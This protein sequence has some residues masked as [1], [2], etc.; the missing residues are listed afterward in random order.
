MS[1]VQTPTQ[2]RQQA[3]P[4]T[5]EIDPETPLLD[6]MLLAA[7]GKLEKTSS[8]IGKQLEDPALSRMP[9]SLM[10]G[11]AIERLRRAITPEIAKILM[12][13]MNTKHGFKTDKGP[14][15]KKAEAMQPYQLE[16]VMDCAIAA[17]LDGVLW[18]GNQFN[19]IAGECYITR[20]GW[21]YKLQTLPG[22]SDMDVSPGVPKYDNGKCYVRFGGTY[23]FNG[24][25][26][27]LKDPAGVPGIPLPIRMDQYS[28]ED[29][30]LGKA[31]SKGL[32]HI[33]RT[34]TG[35]TQTISVSDD[36]PDEII[37]Q[38]AEGRI[39]DQ[40]EADLNELIGEHGASALLI[41]DAFRL[42][43][44][45][46]LLLSDFA[47]CVKRI[48]DGDFSG[49]SKASGRPPNEEPGLRSSGRPPHDFSA[50]DVEQAIAD[51]GVEPRV[52]LAGYDVKRAA[53]L[54]QE[55]RR[56]IMSDLARTIG[57]DGAA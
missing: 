44:G 55:Q 53:D 37:E 47:A 15:Q 3:P 30:I 39:T 40:Q 9:H 28:S 31:W 10:K 43:N 6:T 24:V 13:L 25:N 26:R 22:F 7:V 2:P 54:T 56:A 38:I 51:A 52:F 17:L 49:T 19:I 4:P 20:E 48:K 41:R 21:L 50:D 14:K 46:R 29:Q 12:N 11:L 42:T 18:A 5:K 34:L 33:Y 45:E 27:E 8:V 23:L 16:V 32:R 36:P 1:R 35:T 57:E